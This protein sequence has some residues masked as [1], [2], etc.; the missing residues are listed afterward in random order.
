MGAVFTVHFLVLTCSGRARGRAGENPHWPASP[1]GPC[2]AYTLSRTGV[3]FCRR[4]RG[5]DGGQVEPE[6]RERSAKYPS[7]RKVS[8]KPNLTFLMGLIMGWR[9]GDA[10]SSQQSQEQR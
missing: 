7:V 8:F 9:L 1:P 3:G 10:D 6:G 2:P 5:Q 4:E